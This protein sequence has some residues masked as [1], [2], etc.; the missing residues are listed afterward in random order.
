MKNATKFVIVFLVLSGS[1]FA[2]VNGSA[3]LYHGVSDYVNFGNSPVFNIDS[4]VTYEVWIRPDTLQSGFIFNKWVN[5]QEDKQLV[6]SS[7]HVSFYLFNTFAGASLQTIAVIPLHVFTHIAAT[8]DGIKAKLYVNGVL[9]TMKDVVSGVSNSTGNLFMGFNADRFDVIDPFW[10]AIDEFRIWN[11]VLSE[12]QIQA[13]M[14]QPLT[15][16]EAGLVGCWD[17]DEG[18]G[19]TTA[20][21]TMNGNDGTI[22]GATW[23]NPTQNKNETVST[24]T[25]NISQNYPNPFN[26]ST[27]ITYTLPYECNVEISVTNVIGEKVKELINNYEGAGQHTINFYAG[28]LAS[29]IY[30]YRINAAS[31]DGQGNFINTRKMLLLK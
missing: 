22:S 2:Q 8:Y 29:G 6:Y 24:P 27:S 3:L 14:N 5:F 18:T 10:G 11:T 12:S 23:L 1:L 31:P 4:A 13:T 16:S 7:G 20:D 25:F 30:L 28:D 9:D 19:T 26:P 21:K 15:G 17:F